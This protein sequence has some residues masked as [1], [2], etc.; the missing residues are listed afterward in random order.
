LPNTAI[1]QNHCYKQAFMINII[2]INDLKPHTENSSCACKPNILWQD[3]EMIV[4]HNS[5]DKRELTEV[6][7]H[8]TEE[9]KQVYEKGLVTKQDIQ[10]M[11]DLAISEEEYEM[12]ISIRDVL[13]C[14]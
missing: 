2:P 7:K 5:Y 8:N 4:I 14:L 10:E 6:I 1:E 12:A 13:A 11:L 9:L 3:E